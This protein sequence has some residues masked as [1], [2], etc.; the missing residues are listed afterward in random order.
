MRLALAFLTIAFAGCA[1]TV[2]PAPATTTTYSEPAPEPAAEP[3]PAS[4]C[5]EDCYND[6]MDEGIV[7]NRASFEEADEVCG[8]ECNCY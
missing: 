7:D 3:A 6:C 2:Q 4:S 8:P 5:N 1:A